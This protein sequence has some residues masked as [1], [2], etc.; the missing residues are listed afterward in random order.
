MVG[1]RT[2]LKEG[3]LRSLGCDYHEARGISLFT[4]L[5]IKFR[6]KVCYLEGGKE[7]PH[8]CGTPKFYYS[9][10]TARCFTLSIAILRHDT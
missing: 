4:Q 9:V 1:T 3:K 10:K 2:L 6:K 8:L 7:I 5:L